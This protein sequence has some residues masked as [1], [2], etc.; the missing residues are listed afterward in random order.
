M[1]WKEF[2]FKNSGQ[3]EVTE[4]NLLS[5]LAVLLLIS[6]KTEGNEDKDV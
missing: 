6:T 4:E 2:E 3:E 1:F 5:L